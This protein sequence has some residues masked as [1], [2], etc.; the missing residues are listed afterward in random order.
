MQ[1]LPRFAATLSRLIPAADREPILGDLLED[2]A[3][4]ELS[5]TLLTLWLCAQCSAIAAGL[6][7]DRCRSALTVRPLR[8]MAA[9]LALDGTHAFRDAI[10][11]PWTVLVR[12]VVFC[13]TVATLTI[14]VEMLI[15]ALFSASGL[16][17][18]NPNP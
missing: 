7:I 10:D 12:A 8:E 4:R 11:A 13:A 14:V 1:G 2:A 5:G 18:L 16:V 17:I 9:G 15:A 3:D 6:T